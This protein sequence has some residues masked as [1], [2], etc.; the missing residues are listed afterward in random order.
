MGFVVLYWL[1]E[2]LVIPQS[3]HRT[4]EN[5]EAAHK[6]S[7]G[8]YLATQVGHDARHDNLLHSPAPQGLSRDEL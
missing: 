1:H 3:Q 2:V 7:T 8:G 6:H 5:F 4:K